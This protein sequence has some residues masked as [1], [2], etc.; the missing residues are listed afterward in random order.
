M[1]AYMAFGAA[2]NVRVHISTNPRH[3]SSSIVLYRNGVMH[4]SSVV[5]A[6]TTLALDDIYD[7]YYAKIDYWDGQTSGEP[8]VNVVFPKA[9]ILGGNNTDTV[10]YFAKDTVNDVYAAGV[11]I[12]ART[13]GGVTLGTQITG[14]SGF[15]FWYAAT[16]DTLI[17]TAAW[18]GQYGWVM[19][20]VFQIANGTVDS[21]NGGAILAPATPS[22]TGYVSIYVDVASVL[23]DST[24]G[25]WIPRSKIRLT[26]NLIGGNSLTNGS[27]FLF[28]VSEEKAPDASGRVTF[29]RP[30]NETVSPL[31]SYYELS[32]RTYDLRNRRSGIMRRF[33]VDT[34]TNPI[35]IINTM[36][37]YP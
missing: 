16:N 32:F 10:K 23:I 7:W 29:Q 17:M 27:L 12:T 9:T 35:N 22:A 37:V 5:D 26:L 1:F 30:G 20:T 25:D 18:T 28:P 31:G 24:S 33:I 14:A 19:D 15:V 13:I 21:I 2:Y 11:A 6:D 34:L 36:E 4:D 3:D 8:D